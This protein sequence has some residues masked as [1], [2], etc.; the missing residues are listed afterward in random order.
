MEGKENER[1]KSNDK[2]IDQRSSMGLH[3]NEQIVSLNS[4]SEGVINGPCMTILKPK[5]GKWKP[6]VKSSNAKEETT[7]SQIRLN[8]ASSEVMISS[9]ESKRKHMKSSVKN[10]TNQT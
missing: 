3:N 6:H 5:Q 2:E 7:K 9:P 10:L 8:R 4:S 1:E